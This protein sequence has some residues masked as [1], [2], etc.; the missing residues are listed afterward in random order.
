MTQGQTLVA[1]SSQK[2]LQE[3]FLDRRAGFSQ[4]WPA[5]DLKGQLGLVPSQ[6]T[7]EPDATSRGPSSA[8]VQ[9]QFQSHVRSF[10]IGETSGRKVD[11]APGA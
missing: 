5:L 9:G 7:M 8:K 2:H 6:R 1:P 4:L 10:L 3:S 11:K